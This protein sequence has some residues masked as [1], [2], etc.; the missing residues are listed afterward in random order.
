MDKEKAIKCLYTVN[1]LLLSADSDN[2][3]SNNRPSNAK[4][5]ASPSS[6][7]LPSDSYLT[8]I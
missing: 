3:V 6:A 1:T 7:K 5:C 4:N 8:L 2:A